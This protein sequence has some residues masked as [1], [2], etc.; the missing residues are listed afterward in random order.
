MVLLGIMALV[1]LAFLSGCASENTSNT[2]VNYR[3]VKIYEKGSVCVFYD[4]ET[5]VEYAVR[6]NGHGGTS[7]TLLVDA[8][9]K[10]LLY[11]K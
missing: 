4:T 6:S 7:M 10:P 2:D 3:F 1:G 5:N 11:Q 8:E 9:G